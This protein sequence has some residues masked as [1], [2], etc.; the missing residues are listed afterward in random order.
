MLVYVRYVCNVMTQHFRVPRVIQ[1][2]IQVTSRFKK[3]NAISCLDQYNNR[4]FKNSAIKD[5]FQYS[6]IYGRQQRT[7]EQEI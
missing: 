4:S 6:A 2:I 1:D 5:H 3:A 7:Y